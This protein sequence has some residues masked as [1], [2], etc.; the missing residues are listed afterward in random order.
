M[1]DP[2]GGGIEVD[3]LVLGLGGL[4]EQFV[5]G[6][7]VETELPLDDGVQLVALRRGH[8]TVDGGGVDQQRRRSEAIVVVLEM[9]RMLLALGNVGQKS[10]KAFEHERAAVN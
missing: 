6:G 5:G 3:R 10:A 7:V 8:I 1:G 2:A 4:G 9:G